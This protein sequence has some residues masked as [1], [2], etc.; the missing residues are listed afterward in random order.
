[1]HKPTENF[2]TRVEE[3]LF[4]FYMEKVKENQEKVQEDNHLNEVVLNET[5]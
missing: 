4:N 1:M 3:N 2:K 5:L